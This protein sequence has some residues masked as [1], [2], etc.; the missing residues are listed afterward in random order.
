MGGVG[1][2]TKRFC[3]TWNDNNCSNNRAKMVRL[4]VV[5]EVTP[6]LLVG[7]AFV[8]DRRKD[9]KTMRVRSQLELN[10]S[11]SVASSLGSDG[12]LVGAYEW[13]TSAHLKT[14]VTAQM[15]VRHYDSDSHHLGVSI[16]IN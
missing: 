9:K 6:T 12:I 2:M 8:Y 3:S 5:Q 13:R 1:L 16:E 10:A 15:D 14:R 7:T 11:E 4:D